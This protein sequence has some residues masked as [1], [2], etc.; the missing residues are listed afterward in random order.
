MTANT[1]RQIA[2]AH[3]LFHA[4]FCL[5]QAESQKGRAACRTARAER[6]RLVKAAA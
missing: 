3:G 4:E 2:A 6:E 1:I 5:E